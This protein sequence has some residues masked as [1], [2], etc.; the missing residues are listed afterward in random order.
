M[1][2][3]F[4][5]KVSLGWFVLLILIT[6]ATRPVPT[7]LAQ[8]STLKLPSDPLK[9]GVFIVQ[10]DPGGTFKLQGGLVGIA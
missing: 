6:V 9:F 1:R 7:T 8:D 3:I 5:I 4:P 2:S 10:F